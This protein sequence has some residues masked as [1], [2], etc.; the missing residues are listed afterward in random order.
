MRVSNEDADTRLVIPGGPLRGPGRGYRL[1]GGQAAGSPSR[2]YAPPGI[3]RRSRACGAPGMTVRHGE[4]A[5]ARQA[6]ADIPF[7]QKAR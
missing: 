6:G 3:T 2:R 5:V 7:P 4:A 1:A